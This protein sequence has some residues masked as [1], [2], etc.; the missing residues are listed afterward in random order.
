MLTLN[1]TNP[2][3]AALMGAVLNLGGLGGAWILSSLIV[4]FNPSLTIASSLGAG[5]LLIALLGQSFAA[6]TPTVFLL[7][8][9]IGVLV[10]GAQANIPALCV[11]YYPAA[12]YSSGVGL[13]MAVGRLGSIAGPLIG[14]RL[15]AARVGWVNNSFS[16][17][18]PRRSWPRLRSRPCRLEGAGNPD[19]AL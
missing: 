10:I 3:R 18:P 19:H 4:R 2:Q 17:P 9:A 13:A 12:V 5:A 8:L 14:G 1:G 16:R 15:M 6:P 11:H 7:V